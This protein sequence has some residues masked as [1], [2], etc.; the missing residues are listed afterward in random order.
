M[1]DSI[2]H[3]LSINSLFLVI[4][5][6]QLRLAHATALLLGYVGRFSSAIVP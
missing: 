4:R 6:L 2:M 3:R 5:A 1:S